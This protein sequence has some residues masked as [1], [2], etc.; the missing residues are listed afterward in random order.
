M[1]PPYPLNNQNF[2]T[3]IHYPSI[4]PAELQKKW[5]RQKLFGGGPKLTAIQTY[6]V[7][8]AFNKPQIIVIPLTF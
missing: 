2:S 1:M 4:T 8:L 3:K 5:R 7:C 6:T